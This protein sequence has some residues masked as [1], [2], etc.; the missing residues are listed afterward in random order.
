MTTAIPLVEAPFLYFVL[1]YGTTTQRI[2]LIALT[3]RANVNALLKSSN[4]FPSIKLPTFW[5][6]FEKYETE[7]ASNKQ[8]VLK[9]KI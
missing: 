9:Q 2:L 3:V 6:N 1:Y 5:K 8:L 7:N 4:T